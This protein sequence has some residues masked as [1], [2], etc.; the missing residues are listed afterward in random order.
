MSD[1]DTLVAEYRTVMTAR[2]AGWAKW[3]ATGDAEALS[4]LVQLNPGN[5]PRPLPQPE[6]VWYYRPEFVEDG[7][8]Y[9]P[10]EV[11]YGESPGR[12]GRGRVNTFLVDAVRFRVGTGRCI[13][14]RSTS[15]GRVNWPAS[16]AA[17]DAWQ[18]ENAARTARYEKET[19]AIAYELGVAA[20]AAVPHLRM[21]AGRYNVA[22]I[23][24]PGPQRNFSIYSAPKG[25]EPSA[26][27]RGHDT[28]IQFRAFWDLRH[29]MR[30]E[31][32]EATDPELTVL[33]DEAL[34]ATSLRRL[35][36]HLCMY[37]EKKLARAF[38][39]SLTEPPTHPPKTRKTA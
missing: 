11:R 17:I 30:A 5:G 8:S 2:M 29:G 15:H 38:V 23:P 28:G 35:T 26:C 13:E 1:V 10:Y 4:T 6:L 19:R 31:H 12:Y 34:G 36:D 24:L 9:S 20:I 33:A 7:L 25:T 18:A 27:D 14:N 3:M 21:D 39:A 22:V 32:P 37:V 16:I